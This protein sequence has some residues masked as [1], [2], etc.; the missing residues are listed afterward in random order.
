MGKPLTDGKRQG[1]RWRATLAQGTGISHLDK[2][3]PCSSPYPHSVE[4][5]SEPRSQITL[6]FC[7][8]PDVAPISLEVQVLTGPQRPDVDREAVPVQGLQA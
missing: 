3:S 6:L 4:G 7:S 5:P 8:K 2:W 1:S